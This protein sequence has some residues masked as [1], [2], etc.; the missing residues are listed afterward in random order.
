MRRVL[1]LETQLAKEQEKYAQASRAAG[2]QVVL[3]CVQ[4]PCANTYLL[5]FDLCKMLRTITR[6]AQDTLH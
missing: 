5:T 6:L 2:E 1:Q 4:N 3:A